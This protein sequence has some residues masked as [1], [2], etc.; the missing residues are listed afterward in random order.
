MLLKLK[1][2]VRK[3]DGARTGYI[4]RFPF[5]VVM[6]DELFKFKYFNVS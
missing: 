4:L 2:E 6:G 5:G 1:V 3:M